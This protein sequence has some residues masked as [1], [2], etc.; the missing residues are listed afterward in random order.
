MARRTKEQAA[1]TRQ[2]ILSEA[3]NLFS[4]KG[5]GQTTFVDIAHQIGLSKGA[6]YWHFKTKTDLLVALIEYGCQL[7]ELEAEMTSVV[8]LRQHYVGSARR[9]LSEH[10]LRNFEF[11]IHFQIEWSEQLLA[12]VRNRLASLRE[13]PVRQYAKAI[14]QLQKHGEVAASA[15]V[16]R[17]ASL[18]MASWWG[19]LR[20]TL[21]GLVGE[22]DFPERVGYNFDLLFNDV[23]VTKERYE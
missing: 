13:D 12:E 5:Y 23:V 2:R 3:L 8:L 20:L 4:K 1:E 6:V 7:Q 19:L 11:F 21:I 16:D 15:D 22:A 14:R 10:E 18:L 9:V 17:L